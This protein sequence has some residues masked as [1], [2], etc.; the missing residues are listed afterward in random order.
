MGE[1]RECLVI[2]EKVDWVH[3]LLNDLQ[4]DSEVRLNTGGFRALF[5]RPLHALFRT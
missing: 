5:W 4:T 2:L 3:G 1:R